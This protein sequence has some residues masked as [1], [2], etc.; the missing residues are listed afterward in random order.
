MLRATERVPS[1]LAPSQRRNPQAS[2]LRLRLRRRRASL[3]SRRRR[4][5]PEEPGRGPAQLDA[6]VL[7]A[8]G[9][10]R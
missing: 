3:P 4:P 9:G 2:S 7:R 5:A 8:A 1:L 6:G 10:R